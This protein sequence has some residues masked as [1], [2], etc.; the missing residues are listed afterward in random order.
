MEREW[1][2]MWL[3]PPCCQLL[4]PSIPCL[5]PSLTW[6]QTA[7]ERSSESQGER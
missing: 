7:D 3:D 2:E 6:F 4:E 5:F 1:A